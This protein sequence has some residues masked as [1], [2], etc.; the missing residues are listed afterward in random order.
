MSLIG[1]SQ[2]QNEADS[3]ISALRG[4]LD[5]SD[6]SKL[7]VY[8]NIV[9]N[10]TNQDSIIFYAH[11]AIGLAEELDERLFLIS[12]YLNIGHAQRVKG[13]L[14]EA[15]ETFI[16]YINLAKEYGFT[17][18]LGTGYSSIADVYSVQGN[19]KN[20]LLYYNKAINLFR[21]EN[22][23][24]K[25]ST[26]LLN[27]G[28]EYFK[29]DKLDS[30]LMY[31]EESSELF[32]KLDTKIG[33]AYNL[34]NIGLVYA[35][36]GKHDLAEENIRQASKILEELGDRY[37]IAVYETYMAD[38]YND[39]GDFDRALDHALR[40][41]KIAEEEGLKEQIRDASLKLAELH[42]SSGDY[43]NAF[44]YQSQ[45]VAYK[46]SVSNAETIQT[47][48]DLRTDF[49]VA[50]K[51]AELDLA[52]K[53][54]QTQQIVSIGLIV[55]LSLVG[56]LTYTLFKS[57]KKEKRTNLLLSTQKEEITSQRDQLI[58]LN[59]TKDRFF[60][61][62][63]HDL[64]G[65]VHSFQGITR[66]I[67]AYADNNKVEKIPHVLEMVD[68]SSHQ[69]SGLLDNLLNWALSQQG[70]FPYNPEKLN[71]ALLTDELFLTFHNMA[72]AK[73]I[74]LVKS[75][76]GQI[77][78]WS[79]RNSTMAIF[80]NLVN[81][82]LKFTPER[83]KITLTAKPGNQ[84]CKIL[85]SDTGQ[86]IPA[87]KQKQLF[88]LKDKKQSTVGTAGEKGTGLGLVICQEF[89][90]LNQGDIMVESR[91]N[92]GTTFT[93]TLPTYSSQTA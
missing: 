69:L 62:I 72:L 85:I 59:R 91:E 26:S 77:D 48:A 5:L 9:I 53:T 86:G 20:A 45:Y 58:E 19:S 70:N 50:Q 11:K 75:V 83:G 37:P 64:R 54:K 67:K 41:L 42:Q 32:E 14:E 47:I 61:I 25:L 82:A 84:Y 18:Q 35:K 38:I 93:V 3:L 22:D 30:A 43:Q 13:D 78:L 36:Q 74:E 76:D 51:Q 8:Y 63:S 39:K 4:P 15:M 79:D 12:S 81:N 1:F 52:N 88:Q 23:I 27:T 90:I 16:E 66:V 55:V 71:L 29:L 57:N 46:D 44:K 87:D 10:H 68:K 56:V 80:R 34:G 60:S 73:N 31:F 2:N 40:S 28:D 6:S 21:K 24:V 7:R 89:T 92:S 49:E 33:K 17:V 65:P